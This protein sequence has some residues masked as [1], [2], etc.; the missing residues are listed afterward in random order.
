MSRVNE[1]YHVETKSFNFYMIEI[2]TIN[3]LNKKAHLVQKHINGIVMGDNK[4]LMVN[5]N[6]NCH[7]HLKNMHN[8]FLNK[9]YKNMKRTV[10]W[11][12]SFPVKIQTKDYS[13]AKQ[14]YLCANLAVHSVSKSTMSR[15]T[16]TKVLDSLWEINATFGSFK[17]KGEKH[18]IAKSTLL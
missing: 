12:K 17:V 8:T 2:Y 1:K 15:Y 10:S 18:M 4:W 5:V 16:V 9:Y 3:C 13:S 6:K 14:I 7:H 11:I